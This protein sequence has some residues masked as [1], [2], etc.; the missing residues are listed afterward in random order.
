M[1]LHQETGA[2]RLFP[3]ATPSQARRSRANGQPEQARTL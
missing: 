3:D 2:S 1:E